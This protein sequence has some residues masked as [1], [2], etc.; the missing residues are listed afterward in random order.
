MSGYCASG[1]TSSDTSPAIVVTRAMTIASRGRSTKIAES[2]GL[3]AVERG[4]QRRRLHRRA[5]SQRLRALDDDQFSALQA[6]GDDDV[7]A[8][9]AAGLQAPD[10]RPA[11]LD[12]KDVDAL[13]VGDQRR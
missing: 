11:V 7:L 1:M 12:D 5:R 10:C 13:L 9:G 8:A 4:G 2:I 3:A 6:F